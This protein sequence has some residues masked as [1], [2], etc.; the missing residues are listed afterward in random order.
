[1]LWFIVITFFGSGAG[2][3]NAVIVF[4][5]FGTKHFSSIYGLLYCTSVINNLKIQ[6]L[7]KKISQ[8][9]SG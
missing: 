2:C 8:P 6:L 3:L 4:R 9:G 7:F 1:M 5:C